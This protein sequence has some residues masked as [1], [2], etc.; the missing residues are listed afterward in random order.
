MA[1]TAGAIKTLKSGGIAVIPTDTIYGIVASVFDN[2]AVEKVYKLKR[3]NPQKPCIV[4]ISSF[5][6]LKLFNI[7]FDAKQTK[8]VDKYWPGSTSII[9]PC[10]DSKFRHVHRGTNSI[11]FRLPNRRKLL[12]LISQTGPLIAPSANIEGTPSAQTIIQAKKYFGDQ[13]NCYMDGGK[14][15]GKPSR[16]IDLLGKS[17]KIIRD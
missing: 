1:T 12:K 14:L 4:L 2:S 11:A 5:V 3:R 13:I 9:L 15:I 6:D 17:P 10:V 7:V 16:L 8:Y